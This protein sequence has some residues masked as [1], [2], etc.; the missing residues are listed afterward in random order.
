MLIIRTGESSVTA[1]SRT[2]THQGCTLPNFQTGS[3]RCHCHGSRFNSSG[4]VLNGPATIPLRKYN[5]TIDGD[6]ITIVS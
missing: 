1:L 4:N 2:C 3:S 6:I 5:A